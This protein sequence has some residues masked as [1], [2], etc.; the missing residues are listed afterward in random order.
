[1]L[2]VT[3]DFMWHDGLTALL[4]PS[5]TV[6]AAP[7]EGAARDEAL[8]GAEVMVS[9]LFTPAMAAV[10]KRLRLLVCPPAGTER[11]DRTALPNGVRLE[12]GT[13]HEIPMAEYVM[14]CCVALRQ[15][16]LQGDAAL[17]R[18]R[19]MYG[20]QAG[21]GMQ[22]ELY[23]SQ[24]GLIGFGGIAR[25]IMAR[26]TA[27]GM[28]CSA[29]TMH[30][31]AHRARAGAVAFLG[32]LARAEDVDRVVASADQLVICCELSPATKGLIDARRLRLMKPNAVLVNVARGAIVVEAD[33]FEAL[34][35][36]RIGGAALDVWYRYPPDPKDE[37]L[38]A[39]VPFWELDNVIMTPHASGWT[40]AAKRRRLEAMAHAI[41]EFARGNNVESAL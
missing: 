21:D 7:K 28:T 10:C 38:P 27:F 37:C 24:F 2:V 35:E 36:Q 6:R 26:A 18:G 9:A 15:H 31:A 19:W 40:E 13:G 5:C 25:E 23:G 41:N 14:G 17:R 16:L 12:N 33:L 20:F 11:I 22:D 30:P 4:D 39:D 3:V 32:S 34:K 29:V 1:M 8:A